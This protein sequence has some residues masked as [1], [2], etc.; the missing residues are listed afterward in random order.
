M[1]VKPGLNGGP[2]PALPANLVFG[3]VLMVKQRLGTHLCRAILQISLTVEGEW[4][5]DGSAIEATLTGTLSEDAGSGNLTVGT[6]AQGTW[7]VRRPEPGEDLEPSA[8]VT[9][10][11]RSERPGRSREIGLTDLP[12]AGPAQTLASAP[13]LIARPPYAWPKAPR[14]FQ[15][16]LYADGFDYPRKIQT[17]PN[18]DIFLAESRLGEI[19]ILRGLLAKGK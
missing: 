7:T 6:L 4:P 18:G 5:Q 15:V 9:A 8:A 13:K 19:K 3:G 2:S 14:G 1:R 11:Y 16:S 12:E 10:D 17:A